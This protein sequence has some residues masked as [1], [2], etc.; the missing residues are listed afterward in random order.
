[1]TDTAQIIKNQL[2]KLP[3]EM[4]E[5]I[6]NSKWQEELRRIAEQFKLHID[7]AGDLETETML[8]LIG[9]ASPA[10]F[11]KNLQN[12]LIIKEDLA[13]QIALAV[14]DSIFLRIRDAMRKMYDQME[15]HSS[16]AETMLDRGSILHEIENPTTEKISSVAGTPA[17]R[18]TYSDDM[19]AITIARANRDS[20]RP[21]Q[22]APQPAQQSQKP[23]GSLLQQKLS[24]QVKMPTEEIFVTIPSKPAN[25]PQGGLVPPKPTAPAITAMAATSAPSTMPAPK[26][27][28]APTPKSYPS[29]DPYREPTN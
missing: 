27:S 29:A 21:P 25:R 10:E 18:P 19:P 13:D 24:T 28:P 11:V 15:E 8:I 23:L 20:Q 2:A 6:A 7:Q 12:A 22:A 16:G 14:N 5:A 3:P 4:R 9:I 1:M 26:P 17:S